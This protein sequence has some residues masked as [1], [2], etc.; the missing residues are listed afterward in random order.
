MGG[1][2]ALLAE[3]HGASTESCALKSPALEDAL[4]ELNASMRICVGPEAAGVPPCTPLGLDEE[5]DQCRHA[6]SVAALWLDAGALQAGQAALE[7]TACRML[8]GDPA[9]RCVRRGGD[10]LPFMEFSARYKE[11]P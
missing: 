5:P 10:E 2:L 11:L 7:A 4:H 3:L 1:L 9:A 8:A 6:A